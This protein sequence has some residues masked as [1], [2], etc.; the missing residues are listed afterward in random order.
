M[1]VETMGKDVKKIISFRVDVQLDIVDDPLMS[2]LPSLKT[3]RQLAKKC[4]G[5]NRCYD[6]KTGGLQATF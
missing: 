5:A 6:R 4:I 1:L 3:C 2:T